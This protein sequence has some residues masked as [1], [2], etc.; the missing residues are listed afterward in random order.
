MKTTTHI[1]PVCGN[2]FER[3]RVSKRVCSDKCKATAKAELRAWRRLIEH[4]EKGAILP[5]DLRY[6]MSG[7]KITAPKSRAAIVIDHDSVLPLTTAI[8]ACTVR[9]NAEHELGSEASAERWVDIREYL[10]EERD[11]MRKRPSSKSTKYCAHT[12]NPIEKGLEFLGICAGEY[13]RMMKEEN[14]ELMAL[15]TDKLG[16][17]VAKYTGNYPL[18]F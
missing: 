11:N 2:E 6:N 7:V 9:V 16:N 1:C 13:E 17:L 14:A 5:M 10:T 12:G 8:N 4:A 3:E 18:P 15:I